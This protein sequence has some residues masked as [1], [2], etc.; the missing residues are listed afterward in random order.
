[1]HAQQDE[2]KKFIDFD[3]NINDDFEFYLNEVIA[4]VT[5]DKFDIDKHSTS[6]FLFY[7]FN[8]LRRDLG[9]EAY[10]VRHTIVLDDQHALESL[11]SKDRSYFINRLLEVSSG[12]ISLINLLHNDESKNINDT[13][14]N[15]K[16]AKAIM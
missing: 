2:T 8:N 11:Q 1:M 14:E 4:G 6:K 12:D 13:V 3:S 7:H 10:K 16:S 15:L 9:E 5:D